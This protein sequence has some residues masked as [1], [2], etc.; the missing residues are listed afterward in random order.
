MNIGNTKKIGKNGSMGR[1]FH[2]DEKKTIMSFLPHAPTK[3]GGC[4][5][6]SAFHFDV[7]LRI[8]KDPDSIFGSG[9]VPMIVRFVAS[10]PA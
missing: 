3:H 5:V 8:T 7:G 2:Q 1:A 6:C 9:V 10:M 4:G